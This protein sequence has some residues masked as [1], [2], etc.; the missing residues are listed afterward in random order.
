M[1]EQLKQRLVG[2]AVL[3]LLAVIFIPIILDRPSEPE[4]RIEHPKLPPRSETEFSSRVVPL[5]EPETTLVESERKRRVAAPA[6]PAEPS[7][8]PA[9]AA[10]SPAMEVKTAPAPAPE[11]E[12]KVPPAESGPTAWAIQLGSFSSAQNASALRDRLRKM[13]YVAFIETARVDGKEITRVFVGP[14]LARERAGELVK[15]LKAET[16][17]EGMI[18]QYP[19]S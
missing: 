3:V 1:N 2:A 18:V 13:G 16:D 15:K 5:S 9:A 6:K 7:E 10:E 14:E 12:P 11:P 4:V 17:L 8:P 19:G